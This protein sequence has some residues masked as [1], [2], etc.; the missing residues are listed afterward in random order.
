MKFGIFYEH[1][2]GRPWERGHRAPADPGRP[3]PGRAG[4]PAW[5]SSTSG[6]SST[7][8]SR[9]TPTRRHPRCS[10][11][12]A[13]QRTKRIRLGHGIIL[14]S[15]RFN[16]PAR[17]AERVAMLD[18]VSNGRV[19]FGSGESSSVAEL[20]GFGSNFEEKR[21]A[22][23]EGLEVAVRCMTEEPFTGRR[24]P[25]RVDAAP[26]RG[27]QAGAEAPPPA[28]GGVLAGATPSCSP[29]RRA[30]ARSP[31][32]SSTPKRPVTGWHDYER[33]LAERGVPVGLGRQPPGRLRH[34]R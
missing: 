13:S 4:R 32:P 14:T 28:V 20:G 24:R 26:Q 10:W 30:S 5:A 9:S 18:L 12:P 34:A 7:T 19:D 2:I 23:L 11:P 29:P 33:T 16:H 22:W 27:A 8:S 31:S 21:D 17:T 25:L 3:R 1:Q 6:R 15:P